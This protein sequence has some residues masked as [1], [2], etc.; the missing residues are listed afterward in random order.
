[1]HLLALLYACSGTPVGKDATDTHDTALDDTGGSD[2]GEDGGIEITPVVTDVYHPLEVQY[3]ADG[4]AIFSLSENGGIYASPVDGSSPSVLLATVEGATGLAVLPGGEE[5]WVVGGG[6]LYAGTLVPGLFYASLTLL[7]KDYEEVGTESSS[8]DAGSD[9][10]EGD[11]LNLLDGDRV[12]FFTDA[13]ALYRVDA[14]TDEVETLYRG[15]PLVEPSSLAVS[16]DDTFWVA[17]HAAGSDGSGAIVRVQGGVAEVVAEGLSLGTPA[18]VA[19]TRDRSALLV[20]ALDDTGHSQVVILDTT[21]YAVST[22]NGTIGV[23]TA[24][25]GLNRALRLADAE[26]QASDLQTF[27]WAGTTAGSQGQIYRVQF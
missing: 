3:A 11:E 22:Y 26:G 19:L 23:N 17:D 12:Y 25:G 8:G 16:P 5:I 14:F 10:A 20:S 24:S 9:E 2:T 7:E 18:G 15:A 1:M 6:K 21:T 13:P 4:S 27:V